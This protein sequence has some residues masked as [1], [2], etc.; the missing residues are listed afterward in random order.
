MTYIHIAYLSVI[1]N[2]SDILIFS[3]FYHW[4]RK[5]KCANPC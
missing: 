4:V 1:Y 2:Y 3:W 5:L